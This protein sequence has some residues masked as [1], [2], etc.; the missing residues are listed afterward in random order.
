LTSSGERIYFFRQNCR[1]SLNQGYFVKHSQE[2]NREPCKNAQASP[3]A[4]AKRLRGKEFA[5]F[6]R[7][8]CSADLKD[9]S[10]HRPTPLVKLFFPE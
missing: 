3:R 6:L 1:M 2:C 5:F 7:N 9:A 10:G 8:F 4:W